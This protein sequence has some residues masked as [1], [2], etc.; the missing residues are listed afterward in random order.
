MELQ[1]VLHKRPTC[2]YP[3]A[4]RHLRSSARARAWHYELKGG[5]LALLEMPT[6]E[7]IHMQN[8]CGLYRLEGR[9]MCAL[10]LVFICER[11][12]LRSRFECNECSKTGDTAMECDPPVVVVVVVVVLGSWVA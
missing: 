4:T 6:D 12:Q 8:R 10:D 9:R 7:E 1:F 5:L 3:D 2:N 11:I